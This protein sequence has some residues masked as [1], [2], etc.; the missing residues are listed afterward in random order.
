[1]VAPTDLRYR[2]VEAGIFLTPVIRS[3]PKLLSKIGFPTAV[4]AASMFQEKAKSIYRGPKPRRDLVTEWVSNNDNAVRRWPI[5]VGGL[6]LLAVLLNRTISGV[7]PV[8]D[9]SSSQSRTDILA[10]GLAV[11]NLL[12]GLVWLSI[13]PKS[14]SAVTPQGVG[15]RRINSD[16]PDCVVTELLWVWDSLSSAT[17]CKSLVIVYGN[18]CLLQIGIAAESSTNF[19]DAVAVDATRL[20][21]GSLY[22]G[23]MKSGKQSYLANLSLYPGRSELLFLPWNT[24]AVILQPLGKEGIAVIGGDTIRGFTSVDQA[25]IT[26]IAEKLDATCSKFASTLTSAVQN[27]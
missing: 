7:A 8:A 23:V 10:L 19:G 11:T 13:Q 24:Q 14:I 15:C 3:S 27:I 17:C 16:V 25:W 1:M 5:Y 4:R 26:L 9:A 18:N 21:Q 22:Q 6:S 20:I 12:T 2:F